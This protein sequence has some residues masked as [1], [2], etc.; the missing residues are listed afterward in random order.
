MLLVLLDLSSEPDSDLE[1]KALIMLYIVT[2]GN[3]SGEA[4]TWKVFFI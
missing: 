1:T 4:N 3:H 2:I